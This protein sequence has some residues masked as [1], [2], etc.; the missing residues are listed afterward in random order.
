MRQS[1]ASHGKESPGECSMVVLFWLGI[2]LTAVAPIVIG[3]TGGNASTTWV[4]ALCGAFITF[5]AKL[6]DLTEL[7]MGP[8]RARMRDTIAEAN[9]TVEQL[10]KIATS[11][12]EAFL[13]DSMAGNFLSGMPLAKRLR[14]HDQLVASLEQIGVPNTEIR[15]ADSEWSK[16]IGVIYHRIIRKVIEETCKEKA[17]DPTSTNRHLTEF[18]ELLD[19]PNWSAPRPIDIERF[20]KARG[21]LVPAVEMWIDDYRHFLETG[22]IGRR[23]E[24]EEG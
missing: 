4:A 7:S 14:V 23:A 3:L 13:T 24:F 15:W 19:F 9:A 2:A 20:C 21:L 5:M 8:V 22:E 12:A 11:M 16:G 17:L 18:Q 10:R 1:E 6:R